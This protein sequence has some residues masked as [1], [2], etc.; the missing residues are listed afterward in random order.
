MNVEIASVMRI[1]LRTN[2]AEINLNIKNT[3]C[4]ACRQGVDEMRNLHGSKGREWDWVEDGDSLVLTGKRDANEEKNG[5]AASQI[6]LGVFVKVLFNS[7]ITAFDDNKSFAVAASIA[8][9]LFE[10]FALCFLHQ[11]GWDRLRGFCQYNYYFI[12]LFMAI[13][14]HFH[15][16]HCQFMSNN[17]VNKII[18]YSSI[19]I[20]GC[21]RSKNCSHIV[22]F[23]P[24]HKT[25][26]WIK[27]LT[28]NALLYLDSNVTRLSR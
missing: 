14:F 18:L 3:W 20:E 2:I 17:Y 26:I 16:K 8:E 25:S 13:T 4:A 10:Q 1:L 23:N 6:A 15:I 22:F 21:N 9:E 27:C 7:Y 19:H 28:N 12:H 5:R 11:T 24:K